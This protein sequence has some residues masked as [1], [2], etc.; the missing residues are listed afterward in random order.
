MREGRGEVGEGGERGR[1]VREGRGEVTEGGE[2]GR[3]VRERGSE[4]SEGSE[5]EG[6]DIGLM[7]GDTGLVSLPICLSIVFI[8]HHTECG[9][10]WS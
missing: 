2:R 8:H 4:G 9:L 1:L 3:L 5:W 10:L 6:G 7:T